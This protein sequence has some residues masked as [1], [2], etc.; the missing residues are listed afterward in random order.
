MKRILLV[1]PAILFCVSAFAQNP[2]VG[3]PQYASL[4]SST[5]DVVNR[6]NLNINFAIPIV[7]T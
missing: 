3:L 5:F 6:Q 4:D 7:L 1:V 2:A